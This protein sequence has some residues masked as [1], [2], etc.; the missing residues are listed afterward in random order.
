MLG[1]GTVRGYR[2]E[3]GKALR[4][5]DARVQMG[6]KRQIPWELRGAS[7]IQTHSPSLPAGEC[8]GGGRTNP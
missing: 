8:V 5:K 2:R 6:G 3:T 1:A 4:R 7:L